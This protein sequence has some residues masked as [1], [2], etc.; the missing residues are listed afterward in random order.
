MQDLNVRVYSRCAKIE[1]LG[2]TEMCGTI[3]SFYEFP[4]YYSASYSETHESS[5]G[6]ARVY[7][8]PI[9]YES[10]EYILSKSLGQLTQFDKCKP[11][12]TD[13]THVFKVWS[14]CD[15][16]YKE[17]RL[18]NSLFEHNLAPKVFSVW[19]NPGVSE[20]VSISEFIPETT[21]AL[22]DFE[23]EEKFLA[24][25]DRLKTL[26]YD[27]VD[28]NPDNF[29]LKNGQVVCFDFESWEEPDF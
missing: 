17:M 20:W 21:R 24:L 14:D 28:W 23:Y 22:T 15:L 1:Q 25:D 13:K 10:N 5:S 19:A 26:G 16:A 11:V 4:Q 7:Y 12:W 3:F 9:S 2:L 18:S 27:N 29:G 8:I 6:K